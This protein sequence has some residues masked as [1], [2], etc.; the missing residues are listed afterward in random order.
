MST[1]SGISSAVPYTP[2]NSQVKPKTVTPEPV[3]QP[4]PA[5]SKDADGDNDGSKGSTI[6]TYA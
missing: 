5:A 4:V 3:A 6:N 1:I 2:V